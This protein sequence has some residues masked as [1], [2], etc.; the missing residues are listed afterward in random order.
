[1]ARLWTENEVNF[2]KENYNKMTDKEIG[3]Y[4]NRTSNSIERKR[5][6]LK[7]KKNVEY[8]KVY[9]TDEIAKEMIELNLSINGAYNVLKHKYKITRSQIEY[10]YKENNISSNKA[11]KK[12]TKQEIDFIVNNSD[13][14]STE[15]IAN[16]LNRSESSIIK[17]RHSLGIKCKVRKNGS[18]I[19]TDE[20][21]EYLRLHVDN[22]SYEEIA[23]HLNKTED[24]V[25]V[26]ATRLNMLTHGTKW[27]LGEEELLRHYCNTK[28]IYE[29]V[30]L[31]ERSEKSI[32]H[33]ANELGL[34]VQRKV[35][36]GSK[37]EDIVKEILDTYSIEYK[38]WCRPLKDY[39]YEADFLLGNI[40]IEV[41]GDYWHGNT[42]VFP[43]L[44]EKQVLAIE[45]DK[46]KKRLF[47]NEGY[48][49]YYI[50]EN[51][52]NSNVNKVKD[53]I[54]HIIRDNNIEGSKIG[55]D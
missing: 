6:S 2:L 53:F 38:R 17:K 45:K 40:I 49:V 23:K 34:K 52:I 47:E 27:S 29:L 30:Y 16:K 24:S 19:W 39:S 32:R 37:C 4:L 13:I 9:I 15:E 22:D 14:L 46:I 5:H 43:I 18:T 50:W 21:I 48:K 42:D 7:L 28:N 54:A 35:R 20:E 11:N 26:K 44:D 51:D 3:A 8:S 1:M 31:L 36:Y 41:Q 10:F 33:K 12:W 55:R 25:R